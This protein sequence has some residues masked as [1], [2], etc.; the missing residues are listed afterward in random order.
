MPPITFEE[1]LKW[2]LV[3]WVFIWMY[4]ELRRWWN[5]QRNKG[6]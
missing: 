2:F 4:G 5:V 6:S 3:I 1:L